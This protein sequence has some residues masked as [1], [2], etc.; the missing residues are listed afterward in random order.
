VSEDSVFDSGVFED[1][2][3]PNVAR[4]YDYWLG[5]TDNFEADR[6]AGQAIQAVRPG[7]ADHA[8]ENKQ[9][10]TRAVTYLAAHGIRQ[11]LD[12]GAGLPTSPAR[13]G[14]A[15]P[16]W[17][18]TH[19]A[20]RAVVPD[21]TV[22]YLDHDPVAVEHS[23]RVLAAQSGVD[24]AGVVATGGDMLEP[25]AILADPAVRAAGFDPA[26]PAGVLL[27]CVLHFVPEPV[28][29]DV[30]ARFHRALAPGSYLVVSIGYGQGQAG[31]DFTR[32]YNSQDGSQIYSHTLDEFAA[33]FDGLE[34]L[35]PGLADV[36]A[37]RPRRP[38]DSRAGRETMIV[39][40][41][42]RKP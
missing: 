36:T 21:A 32:T 37:W 30:V 27:A 13:D 18:A 38:E 1:G 6:Q 8:R 12:V 7:I 2:A 5:G 17:R 26:E 28:A 16:L 31:Q 3:R 42:A 24:L 40:G 29:R 14:E 20:A 9:F 25:E 35:S 33:W 19:E 41:V 10:L 23:R 15:A 39:G 4:I 34:L 11:F 22:A